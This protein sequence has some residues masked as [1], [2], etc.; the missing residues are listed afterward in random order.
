MIVGL[1]VELGLT[2]SKSCSINSAALV[3]HKLGKGERMSA[4]LD[5]QEEKK[6]V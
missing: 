1:V 3:H 2:P 5:V 4:Y 6:A